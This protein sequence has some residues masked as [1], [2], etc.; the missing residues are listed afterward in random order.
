MAF[1]SIDTR[2]NNIDKAALNQADY[3]TFGL[4]PSVFNKVTISD[5]DFTGLMNNTRLVASNTADSVTFMDQDH[6]KIGGDDGARVDE[7]WSQTNI[8]N[9]INDDLQICKEFV[10]AASG[11]SHREHWVPRHQAYITTL[12]GLDA[13]TFSYPSPKGLYELLHD[14]GK[15]F[16]NLTYQSF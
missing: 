6:K 5:E 10:E 13:S 2:S 8:Q 7:F 3:D 11:R 14:Q 12:E 1:I 16:L 4:D 15:D 9:W